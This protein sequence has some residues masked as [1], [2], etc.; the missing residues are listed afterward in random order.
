M[1]LVTLQKNPKQNDLPH[2]VTHRFLSMR[3]P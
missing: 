3:S 1:E 2:G